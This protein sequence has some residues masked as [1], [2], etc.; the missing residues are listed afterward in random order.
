MARN[1]FS[2]FILASS[3]LHLLASFFLFFYH[4]GINIKNFSK[5][6]LVVL[7]LMPI[8]HIS[9]VKT[10]VKSQEQEITNESDASRKV[11]ESNN[12][13]LE[14][15]IFDTKTPDELS[16]EIA[17]IL[18][19]EKTTKK[20]SAEVKQEILPKKQKEKK[21]THSEI[22]Q[23]PKENNKKAKKEK[24]NN[25][26]NSLLKNLEKASQ[27]EDNK[28]KN[29]K[30][31]AKKQ[32]DP[33]FITQEAS[34]FDENNNL[35]LSEKDSIKAALMKAWNTPIAAAAKKNMKVVF[36]INLDIDGSIKNI[37]LLTHI[38]DSSIEKNL[39]RAFL[40]SSERAILT[41]A[42]FDWLPLEHYEGWKKIIFSFT[43]E[44]II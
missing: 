4:P 23:I 6:N 17:T 12:K 7:E 37:K 15:K 22:S 26:F 42:P 20:H 28:A 38:C 35:S 10:Q 39:C 9:N 32:E 44:G 24:L 18:P 14:E 21:E 25:E 34:E 36:E 41:A 8:A 5:E 11:V 40:Y 16:S 1:N 3:C 2:I 13:P 30:L 19:K 31:E 29:R 33:F 27:G 43:P